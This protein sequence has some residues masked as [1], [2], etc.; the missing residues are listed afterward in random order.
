MRKFA[1]RLMITTMLVSSFNPFFGVVPAMAMRP[2]GTPD[3][4]QALELPADD[5]TAPGTTPGAP[6]SGTVVS[7]TPAATPAVTPA[8]TPATTPAA[9]KDKKPDVPN[10]VDLVKVNTNAEEIVNKILSAVAPRSPEELQQSYDSLY[11]KIAAIFVEPIQLKQMHFEVY[12]TKYNGKIKNWQDYR[13]A[14][15]DMVTA[16]HD[17]GNRWTSYTDPVNELKAAIGQTEKLLPLGAFLHKQDDG[18]FL[19]ESIYTTLGADVGGIQEGDEIVSVDGHILKGLTKSR[20]VVRHA[21]PNALAPIISVIALN[22]AYLIV[23]VVVVETV[24]VYPGLGQLMVDEVSK[25]DVP[26]V[27]AC[28]LIFAATFIL[29]N[30][31]A[32]I[33]AIMSNPRLRRPR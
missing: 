29:L 4:C 32:D 18:T 7:P 12:K 17:R 26:V 20:I 5:P 23:G 25:H 3:Y 27:Q 2:D 8:P 6:P 13:A 22:L 16:V 28:G 15:K 9:D 21:L 19:V 1:N 10:I 11:D 14:L 24:Y 30:M 31:I 33:L